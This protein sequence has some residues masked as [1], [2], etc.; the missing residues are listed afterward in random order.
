MRFDQGGRVPIQVEFSNQ[1]PE[2]DDPQMGVNPTMPI[3]LEL[4]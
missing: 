4:D 1:A 3:L 2:L